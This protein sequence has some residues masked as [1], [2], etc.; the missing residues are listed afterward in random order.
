M[1]SFLKRLTKCNNKK[2]K[3]FIKSTKEY[4]CSVCNKVL[5]IYLFSQDKSAKYGLQLSKCTNCK[6]RKVDPFK[7]IHGSMKQRSKKR[8][9]CDLEFDEKELKELAKKQKCKCYISGIEMEVSAFDKHHFGISPERIDNNIGYTKRNVVFICKCFQIGN[10]YNLTPTEI[11]NLL[12]YNRDVDNYIFKEC[13]FIKSISKTDGRNVKK[14]KKVIRN[15]DSSG[16]LIS[17]SCGMCDGVF[18]IEKFSNFKTSNCKKCEVIRRNSHFNTPRGFLLKIC[19]EARKSA[20]KRNKCNK[21]DDNSDECDENLFEI[22][23]KVFL[24][25]KGRCV[26]TGIPLELKTGHIHSAS[27]DRLDNSK[28]YVEGNVQLIVAPLNTAYKPNNRIFKDVIKN[29]KANFK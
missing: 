3:E 25:Q 9:H 13:E 17:K 1:L 26:L 11:I 21:R 23:S 12:L 14:M 16:K 20:N 29:V 15:Y 7:I 6:N 4:K 18:S 22:I 5:P 24:K 19:A 2:A 8:K 10:K 27:I 28:G